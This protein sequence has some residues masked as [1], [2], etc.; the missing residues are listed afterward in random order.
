MVSIKERIIEVVARP[1]KNASGIPV[2]M[3]HFFYDPDVSSHSDGNWMDTKTFEAQVKYLVDNDY[4]FPT[5]QEVIDY[6]DGKITLPEK[7]VVITADDSDVTFFELAVPIIQKYNVVATTFAIGYYFGG[8]ALPVD[9][10]Y[11]ESH[12]YDMHKG[13]CSG[14][15]HGGIMQCIDHDAGVADLKKSIEVNGDNKAIA[16]PFGD[17]ND[18]V[19]NIT[20][21]AGIQLGFTTAWGKIR[22]GMDKL[23]LPRIRISGGISIENFAER[24]Q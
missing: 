24:L 10:I 20:R 4:Y 8:P 6:L 18:N 3:Y 15:G 9:N 7:S 23:E 17:V 1:E 5:W 13:G 22:P 19:K 16:Y 11:F 21:D 2:L 12:T 14:M